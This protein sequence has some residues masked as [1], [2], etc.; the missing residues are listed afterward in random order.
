M[1]KVEEDK[2]NIKEQKSEN[3]P[4]SSNKKGKTIVENSSESRDKKEVENDA[5]KA[6]EY[7]C[8]S[9]DK[10]NNTDIENHTNR[11]N[12]D[13]KENDIKNNKLNIKNNINM[14]RYAEIL[15]LP[16]VSNNINTLG[17]ENRNIEDKAADSRDKF[18]RYCCN[19]YSDRDCK[20]VIKTEDGKT[21][22]KMKRK[23]LDQ[24]IEEK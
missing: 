3:I 2:M 13:I 24:E 15:Y 17:Y 6:L 9:V 12:K 22:M 23:K 7:C 5:V 18:I 19:G 4:K 21:D 10:E 1:F 20:L 14:D 8:N 16:P 11:F